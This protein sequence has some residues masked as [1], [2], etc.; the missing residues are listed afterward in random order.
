MSPEVSGAV[1][2]SPSR[3]YN[4]NRA[5]DKVRRSCRSRHRISPAVLNRS[6]TIGL[7][8]LLSYKTVESPLVQKRLGF[9]VT[10]PQDVSTAPAGCLSAFELTKGPGA[11]D[12]ANGM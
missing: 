9:A 12:R 2:V 1:R 5:S 6:R 10:F 7:W 8:P 3:G 11:T 4:G